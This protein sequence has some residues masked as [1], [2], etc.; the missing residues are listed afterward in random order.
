MRQL[1]H[2]SLPVPF[3]AEDL[4]TEATNAE[5]W[6]ITIVPV[7]LIVPVIEVAVLAFQVPAFATP[8]MNDPLNVC[9]T[10]EVDTPIL[11]YP[12]VVMSEP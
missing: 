7:L 8:L 6:P 4:A 12:D 9:I 1:F 11:R 3:H 2:H 5:P 10:H